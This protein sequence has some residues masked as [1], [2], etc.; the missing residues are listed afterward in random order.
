MNEGQNPILSRN[1]KRLGF[2]LS[3]E[4]WAPAFAGVTSLGWAEVSSRNFCNT[5]KTAHKI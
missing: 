1:V 4:N 2:A 3:N 5:P